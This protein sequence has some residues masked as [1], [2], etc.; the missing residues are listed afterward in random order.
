M[1]LR[2]FG[3]YCNACFGILFLSILCTYCIHFSWYCFISFTM[4]CAPVSSLIHLFFSLSS[5]VIPSKC[6]KNFICVASKR[7]SS[8]SF[9]T[10]ASLP[11]KQKYQN[12]SATEWAIYR[13][14]VTI[15]TW[16]NLSSNLWLFHVSL[17]AL[18]LQLKPCYLL[19]VHSFYT[20]HISIPITFT[21]D[22]HL[23]LFHSLLLIT[24]FSV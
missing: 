13:L 19:S 24:H 21:V 6:L 7:C 1:F 11:N 5:F 2:P 9:S 20:S 23:F 15:C 17:W 10:Q 16:V 22:L 12:F 4:F 3:R 8:L 18:K 14:F